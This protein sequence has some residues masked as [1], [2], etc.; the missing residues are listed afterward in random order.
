MKDEA[1]KQAIDAMNA[2]L[3]HMGMD[4]D[5]FNKITYDRMRQAIAAAEKALAATAPP[6]A[7]AAQPAQQE[8]V[9][10]EAY[11]AIREARENASED[12]YFAARPEHDKDLN[13]LMFRSGF[14][15]GYPTTPPA[16]P[17]Q[18]EPVAWEDLLGAIARGW[19]HPQNARKTMDVQLGVAIAKEIQDLYTTPPAALQPE[20]E[21]VA[22]FDWYDNAIW[23][24]EDFKEGCHR[25]WHAAITYATPPAAQ[26]TWVGLR[27]EEFHDLQIENI[28]DPWANFKAIE[29][30]LKEKNT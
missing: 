16:Q 2:M 30:K 18:Q 11:M 13:R 15:R 4:E 27:A 26:R 6:A 3:T 21:P 9:G 22:F 25:S 7:P 24:N 10:R 17:A 1:F 28:D 8:L 29:A 5:E 19:C 14:Y 23:G 12:A 20:Q